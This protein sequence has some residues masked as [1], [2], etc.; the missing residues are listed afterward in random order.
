[1]YTAGTLDL[2][3]TSF[4]ANTADKEGMAMLVASPFSS[5]RVDYTNVS[6]ADNAYHCPRGEYGYDAADAVSTRREQFLV[7]ERAVVRTSV[8][9][10]WWQFAPETQNRHINFVADVAYRVICVVDVRDQEESRHNFLA[11]VKPGL[12]YHVSGMNISVHGVLSSENNPTVGRNIG[13][14]Y[15]RKPIS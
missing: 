4:E 13:M 1:M 7:E 5:S 8:T 2:V 3:S 6:F 9:H 14:V 15:C 10:T 11:Q 12:V